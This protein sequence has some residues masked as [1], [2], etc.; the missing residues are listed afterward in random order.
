[1]SY[2]AGNHVVTTVRW[3]IGTASIPLGDQRT[4]RFI[5]TTETQATITPEQAAEMFKL[6]TTSATK[7][8][9]LDSVATM[10]DQHPKLSQ[11]EV[12]DMIGDTSTFIA[13]H[14]HHRDHGDAGKKAKSKLKSIRDELSVVKVWAPSQ[15]VDGVSFEAHKV[16]NRL[17]AAEGRKIL[18]S[19]VTEMGG[20]GNVTKAA[21]VARLKVAD[22]NHV[23]QANGKKASTTTTSGNQ[24]VTREPTLVEMA[25]ML[26]Q[27]L[28]VGELGKD[29][30]LASNVE[31]IADTFEAF[32]Q[33]KQAKAAATASKPKPKP[34]PKRPAVKPPVN[35]P[36]RPSVKTPSVKTPSVKTPV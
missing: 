8:A 20:P 1:M 11:R 30:T 22:P 5:M 3:L 14:G 26:G 36:K 32:A 13:M 24:V 6:A 9:F 27:K 10:V 23:P 29:A 35:T 31:R 17:G 12:V 2:R 16:L 33:R 19:L 7:W 18:T 28:T 15:R 34:K 25:Q 4:R 21:V